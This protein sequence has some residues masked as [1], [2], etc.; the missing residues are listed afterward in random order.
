MLSVFGGI[1]RLRFSLVGGK[2]F[3]FKGKTRIFRLVCFYRFIFWRR[4]FYIRKVSVF[5]V[6]R[7]IVNFIFI[8]SLK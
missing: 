8:F 6:S 7:F 3:N 2:V 5:G 1:Y 4:R